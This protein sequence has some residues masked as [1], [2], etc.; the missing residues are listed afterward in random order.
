MTGG[1]LAAVAA[2]AAAVLA[3]VLM[4]VGTAEAQAPSDRV[5]LDGRRLRLAMV[6]F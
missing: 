3:V 1:P 6:C 2:A 4:L 5:V